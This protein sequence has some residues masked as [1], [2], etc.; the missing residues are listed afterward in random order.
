[1]NSNVAIATSDLGAMKH[2]SIFAGLFG[3]FWFTSYNTML[4]QNRFICDDPQFKCYLAACMV[5]VILMAVFVADCS[6]TFVGQSN[7]SNTCLSVLETQHRGPQFAAFSASL[8]MLVG[9]QYRKPL[10]Y[11]AK[12][13]DSDNSSRIRP[14]D[15]DNRSVRMFCNVQMKTALA[16]SS[17]W[18]II[19]I[20]L[21]VER[22]RDAF[23]DWMN[24]YEKV[25][26]EARY[27]KL[28][29]LLTCLANV[30][31]V[32]CLVVGRCSPLMHALTQM[33]CPHSLTA[34]L[35]LDY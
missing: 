8:F 19:F 14:A 7:D 29:L 24:L 30:S 18:W 17:V 10:L 31:N 1:M 33:L 11:H 34:S 23:G 15:D 21:V 9:V 32:V 28:V 5:L 4:Y 13:K 3:P 22:R 35:P 2:T 12:S 26:H 27:E 20:I 25:A 16:A 6:V